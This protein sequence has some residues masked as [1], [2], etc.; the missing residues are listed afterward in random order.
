LM[1]LYMWLG[2]SNCATHGT[3]GGR[4]LYFFNF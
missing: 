2:T 1:A 3:A 4:P